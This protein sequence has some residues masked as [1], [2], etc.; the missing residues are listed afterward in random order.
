LHD[1]LALRART[2]GRCPAIVVD[3]LETTYAQLETAATATA[4]RLLALGVCAGDRVATT[5]APSLAFATLLHALPR[6][7][8]VLVPLN[9]RLTA[10]ERR[11]QVADCAASLVLDELPGGDQADLALR[12]R[13]EPTEPHCV[14]YS[15]GTSGRPRAVVLTHANHSASAIAFAWSLGVDPKDR[16]LC[17]LP[18]FHVGGLAILIR[19]AIY[20][21]AAVLEESFDE[22]AVAR[23]LG[24]AEIT[25]V[26]LVPT[27]LRRL[28]AAGLRAAP[29]LRA[30]LIGG[31]PVPV[32]LLEWAATHDFPATPTYG[33]TEAASAIAICPA[34]A[35]LARRGVA[36]RPVLGAQIRISSGGEILV[37]GPMVARAA[38]GPDGWLHTRDRGRLDR[39][40]YLWVEG[41]LGETI[42]SGGE[43]V[44]PAEVEQ[45]LLAHPAVRDAAVVG[46]PDRQW[47]ERVTAYVVLGEDATEDELIRHCRSRLAAYKTPKA[48]CRIAEIPR[49]AAGKILRSQLAQPPDAAEGENRDTGWKARTATQVECTSVIRDADADLAALDGKTVAIL[50]YGSQGHA[51]ALNLNDSG[52][53]VVVG[54]REGS[55]SVAK[56]RDDG[57]EVLSIAAAARRG[58]VVM[59]LLPDEQ[60][61]GVWESQIREEIVA[62]NLLMFAH[63]FTIHFGQIEPGPEIDVAMVAPKGPG[64]LVRRQ[65]TEGRGVPG[66]MAI[67]GDSTGA[68]RDLALAYAKGIGCTRAGVIETSFREETETDLFGEQ[69]VLCGGAS[70]LVQAGYETLVEAGYDPRLAY[71]ECLHELKLIVDLMYE[72]GITGMRYSISNTAEYGDLTRGKRVIGEPTRQ[73]MREILDEIQSGEFAREWIAEHRAGQPA[74][75]LMRQQGKDH[76]IEIEG[77]KLRSTMDWIDQEF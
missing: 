12:T 77:R 45:A 19:S 60:Q 20:G 29:G 38:L 51:H 2:H 5:L 54:L 73:A 10:G 33:M 35:A 24:S 7:G 52:V 34:G 76:Q 15:S 65:F 62:G 64:H 11:W 16:W 75:E 3:D 17:V 8:A 49:N 56:A 57:L 27:M 32:D 28:V 43:N 41:R 72:K 69:A 58:D 13:R 67:H 6:L 42:I 37:R 66:L 30:A 55:A 18:V 1:W 39:D 50:G 53:S 63:G 59:I 48:I 74:F 36:G 68:V 40:G 47:G 70:E 71:F 14:I 44:A 61:A 25:L 23:A 26:S 46:R 9:T 22:H 4:R 31:A 21:T